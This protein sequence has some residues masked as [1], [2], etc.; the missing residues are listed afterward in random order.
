MGVTALVMAGGKGTRMKSKEE[1]PLLRVGGKPLIKHVLNALKDAK[2]VDEIIVAVSEHT[3][4]TA[5]MVKRFSV[6]VLKTPGKG[7]CLDAQY[8]IKQL[9]LDTVLTISADLPLITSEVI[10]E[11]IERYEQCGKPALTVMLPSKIYKRPGLDVDYV[12]EVNGRSLTPVGINVVDG[13]KINEARLE[14]EIFVIPQEEI[15]VN[16]NRLEDLKIAECLFK[17]KQKD[18]EH[19]YS[20]NG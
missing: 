8:A 2:K 14:E 16:V 9:K 4:K 19:F 15:A 20:Q 1:K 12:F 13:R 10:D 3:P 11:V 6:K 5:S 7:F 17:R 18:T